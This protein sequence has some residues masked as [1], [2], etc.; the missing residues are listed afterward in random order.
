MIHGY[1]QL[2]ANQVTVVT[3]IIRFYPRTR[4]AGDTRPCGPRFH[5]NG[6]HSQVG[7]T[8][9]AVVSD[10][11]SPFRGW[12]EVQHPAPPGAAVM[13]V[14]LTPDETLAR[15]A[16]AFGPSGGVTETML[17]VSI[18]DPTRGYGR[19]VLDLT[20]DADYAKIAGDYSNLWFAVWHDLSSAEAPQ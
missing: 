17:E 7:V 8:G 2:T 14:S 15:R 3:G 10:P 1:A 5:H 6:A 20:S 18:G 12:L 13:H 16:A 9:V 4:P 11:A 19:R